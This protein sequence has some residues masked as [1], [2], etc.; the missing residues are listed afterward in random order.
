ME[1]DSDHAAQ[2]DKS[3]ALIKVMTTIFDIDS[4]E[5]QCVIMKGLL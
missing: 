5:Q 1:G 4:F 3:R 2:Q